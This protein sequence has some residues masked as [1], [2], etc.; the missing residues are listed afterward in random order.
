LEITDEKLAETPLMYSAL[1]GGANRPVFVETVMPLEAYAD[2]RDSILVPL[3]FSQPAFKR[4]LFDELG[5]HD[6]RV[7]P[8]DDLL[9]I[10]NKIREYADAVPFEAPK[11]E[12]YV[13]KVLPPW[14][15]ILYESGSGARK[16][17]R[18]GFLRF[19]D[20]LNGFYK[21]VIATIQSGQMQY[22]DFKAQFDKFYI[23]RRQYLSTVKKR[24]DNAENN[25]ALTEE[26]LKERHAEPVQEEVPSED[27]DS[28]ASE[29]SLNSDLGFEKVIA[30]KDKKRNRKISEEQPSE[31]ETPSSKVKKKNSVIQIPTKKVKQKPK[32]SE[33]EVTRRVTRSVRKT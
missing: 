14:Y 22:S 3:S 27:D 2:E 8:N 33:L 26:Q 12:S 21:G 25:S 24:R 13:L 29:D 7:D 28:I 9:N 30:D 11:I 17:P 4:K 19:E 32:P 31:L 16:L 6:I 20:L 10:V 15:R 23:E 1:I 5:Q 18:C